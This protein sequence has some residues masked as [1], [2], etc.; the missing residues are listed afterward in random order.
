MTSWPSESTKAGQMLSS[1]RRERR[2]SGM[3]RVAR[4]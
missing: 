3:M 1:V 4:A 2:A